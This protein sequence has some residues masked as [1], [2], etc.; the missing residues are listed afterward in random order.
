MA[1]R[2]QGA[3]AASTGMRQ[4][5]ERRASKAGPNNAGKEKVLSRGRT[6][7]ARSNRQHVTHDT[8]NES[9]RDQENN[10]QA[11]QRGGSG[12]KVGSRRVK[13]HTARARIITTP[14]KTTRNRKGSFIFEKNDMRDMIG[15][16]NGEDI[17]V[18]PEPQLQRSATSTPWDTFSQ[19]LRQID[20]S[21]AFAFSQHGANIDKGASPQY[22]SIIEEI[23]I[24]R[25][26]Q[27]EAMKAQAESERLGNLS[28]PD[29]SDDDSD[30]E[31]IE[32]E[33]KMSPLRVTA[34]RAWA[35]IRRNVHEVAMERRNT[36]AA[37]NWSFLNQTIK[38]MTNMERGRQDLYEKYL[39]R[40]DDWKDGIINKHLLKSI[41]KRRPRQ[42]NSSPNNSRSSSPTPKTAR[43]EISKNTRV[44]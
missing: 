6:P 10:V 38:R 34:L 25:Q 15:G 23:R 4:E 5:Q 3:I 31:V 18:E 12:V 42:P 16:E 8:V 27:I 21:P 19:Q 40:P 37:L 20:D 26:Q 28:F 36:G 7:T 17:D 33:E 2:S 41:E 1:S 39:K 35:K 22:L 13:A 44:R 30:V 14:G 32:E 9:N 29:F 43:S 24:R 11:V